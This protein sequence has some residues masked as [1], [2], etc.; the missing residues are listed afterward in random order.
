MK[1]L[2]S[3]NSITK[4]MNNDF[5]RLNKR[6]FSKIYGH[7]RPNTYEISSKNYSEG[8][9]NYFSNFKKKFFLREK[10][11]FKTNQKYKIRK[12]LK[13]ISLKIDANKL[14]TFIKKSI[15]HRE[16][17]KFYFTKIINEIFLEIRKISKK[18]KIKDNNISFLNIKTILNLYNNFTNDYIQ[19]T[20][21]EDICENKRRFNFNSKIILPSVITSAED[22][23]FYEEKHNTPTFITNQII[24]SQVLILKTINEKEYNLKNKIICITNADPG[25]DFIFNKGICGLITAYGGPNSHMAIRCNELK[26]PAAIGIGDKKF[27][28]INR[29]S[30]INLNCKQKRIEII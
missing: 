1:F 14:I 11:I 20:M 6:N 27:N 18:N 26:I 28:E 4:K 8:Y 24:S 10:F 2:N 22:V 17:S 7:L 29:F 25:F 13:K 21:R 30:K 3:I 15:Y 12:E 5:F 16:K 9:N 23:L 19:K